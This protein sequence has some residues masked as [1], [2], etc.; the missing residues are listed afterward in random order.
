ME[1]ENEIMLGFVYMRNIRFSWLRGKKRYVVALSKGGS[2]PFEDGSQARLIVYDCNY[3]FLQ[4][5]NFDVV[6]GIRGGPS[7]LTLKLPD[8]DF[9]FR[10][11]RS[12]Q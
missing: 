1:R 10:S 11:K 7:G 5:I 12:Y 9:K 3:E 6:L 4:Q 2:G 8:Q